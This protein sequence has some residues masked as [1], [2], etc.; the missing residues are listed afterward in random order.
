MWYIIKR[1][2]LENSGDIIVVFIPKPT[3]KDYRPGKLITLHFTTD[4]DKQCV[5]QHTDLKSQ[6]VPVSTV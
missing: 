6:S 1:Y 3:P 4:L 5:D 2:T